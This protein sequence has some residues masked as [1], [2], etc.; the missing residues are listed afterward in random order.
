MRRAARSLQLLLATSFVTLAP[1]QPG[2]FVGRVTNPWFPL[3]PGTTFVYK[4]EKDGSAG[5]D[6]VTVT[7]EQKVIR[8][9]HCT[10]VHDNLYEHGLLVERTTDWY[11]QDARGT[12]WYFG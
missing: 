6:V 5:R 3:K 12:V 9:V 10:T 8:G 7:R 2:A 4:G 1:P 11:A